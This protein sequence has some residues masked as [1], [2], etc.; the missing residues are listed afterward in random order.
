MESTN[1]LN[2]IERAHALTEWL[3][4]RSGLAFDSLQ[5]MPG[6]ASFRRYFRVNT[7]HGSFVAMDAPPPRENCHP[8]VAIANALRMM[9]LQ[10]PEI[11]AADVEQGFLLLTDFGDLTY[12]K[13]CQADNVDQLYQVA[14]DALLILQACSRVDE[15]TIPLFTVEFMQQEW[16]WHKEWFLDKLLGLTLSL[17]QEKAMDQCMQAVIHTAAM[18]PQVFMHRDY[19]SANLMVLPN[20]QVGIL[21]F[22]D[23]FVGPL[24]YDLVSML[25]DCYIAW[26]D[27][28]VQQW[29]LQYWRKWQQ[30]QPG[31]QISEQTFLRWFDWMGI[32]RHIK[33]LF[34]FARKRVRDHQASYLKHVPR[35]LNYIIQVSGR[36]PE[37]KALHDYYQQIVLP[38]VEK[39]MTC[40]P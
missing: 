10:A 32:E 12:L 11:I 8:F 34:T 6:D 31:Q 4:T 30:T 9:K 22:Q 15:L 3:K 26:P 35:T 17:Q 27:A 33:A 29:A 16:A 21:D 40:A 14:L 36:Y 13:A 19:H 39:E 25:R 18:Q 24:T 38:V 23:A 28:D 7:A 20:N 37:L 2:A 5:A 1:E